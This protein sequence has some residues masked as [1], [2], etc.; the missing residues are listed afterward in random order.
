MDLPSDAF[1]PSSRAEW[2]RW[3]EENHATS[4]GVWLVSARRVED[5]R[6]AY[7][8]VIQE[9]L[10]F[11]W[12]DSQAKA[13]DEQFGLLRFTPRKRGSGWARTNKERVELLRAAGLMT[14][15][16]EAVIDVAK[17]DG[18]W[19]VLDGPE[20]LEVPPDL[21]AALDADPP[22]RAHFD[23]FPPSA[24]KMI[25]AWIATAKRPET[26]ATRIAEAAGRAARNQRAR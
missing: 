18:S 21:A 23:A 9:A 26:R 5:R 24:R 6:V 13:L 25:L 10:C 11:G 17:A 14:P 2:R 20:A 12:V 1:Q 15:A 8:D 22:A 7:E 19:S 4:K 3:L 16:G